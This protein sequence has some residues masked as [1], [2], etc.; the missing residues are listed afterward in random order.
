[1]SIFGQHLGYCG[2]NK[3]SLGQVATHGPELTT[4]ATATI[5]LKRQRDAT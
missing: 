5:D 4:G 1:V 3:D 2:R